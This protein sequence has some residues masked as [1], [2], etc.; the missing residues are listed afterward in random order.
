MF[1][2][3]QHYPHQ[4]PPEEADVYS[5]L[6]FRFINRPHPTLK[7]FQSYYDL[8]P[9]KDWNGKECQARGLSVY[10]TVEDCRDVAIKVPGLRKKQIAIGTINDSCGLLAHTPSTTSERHFTW[11]IPTTHSNICAMFEKLELGEK[12]YV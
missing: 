9:D 4:C 2:W 3:P 5:G 11:W 1:T 10:K 12:N 8:K 6:L 7:D